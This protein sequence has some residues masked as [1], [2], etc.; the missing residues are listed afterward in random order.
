M[1]TCA[2]VYACDAVFRCRY[3][4]NTSR[5]GTV[6]QAALAAALQAGTIAGAA[7]DVFDPE[8][9]SPDDPIFSPSIGEKLIATP[10]AIC[11]T[12]E[13]FAGIGASAIASALTIMR[14]EV[15]ASLVDRSVTDIA[16]FKARLS[17]YAA[18][19]RSNTSHGPT[20]LVKIP[21]R[22]AHDPNSGKIRPNRV[23]QVRLIIF[24]LFRFVSSMVSCWL[25]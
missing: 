14:G 13:C 21:P 16:G 6:D 8:P 18:T 5:G 12:D 3:L 10:H 23:K 11:W 24:L 2:H 20:P 22:T 7:I 4:I 17:A 15:P 25:C 1:W 19:H 9:P